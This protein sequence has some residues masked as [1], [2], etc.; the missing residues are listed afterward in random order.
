MSNF[1]GPSYQLNTRKADVQ[2]VVNMLPVMNEVPGGKSA[3]YMKSVPGLEVFSAYSG[4]LVVARGMI[5][6]TAG[7]VMAIVIGDK[8]Y[9]VGYDGVRALLGTLATSTGH[10]GM[11]VGL[12]QLVVVDGPNGY[13]V[14]LDT[15][16]FTQITDPA[17]LGSNTVDYLGGYFTF[18]DPD[19]QTFYISALEDALTFDALE[20]ATANSSPDKLVGQSVTS[21][22]LVL[23]GQV[24]TEV[25]QE[26]G[27]TDFPFEKNT[28]VYI[29]VGLMAAFTAKDLDNSTFWLGKDERGAGIVYKLEGFRA[30]RVSTMAIEQTIQ[31]AISEGNDVSTAV[32]YTY[33]Q[34]GHSFYVLQIP[35]LDTTWTYDVSSKQW[36]ERAELVNGD[37]EQHRGRFHC[38]CF[39]KHLI[40]GDDDIIYEYDVDANTN[41]GDVLVRD[42]ISPHSSVPDLRR[43]S[44]GTFELDCTVGYGIAGQAQASVM[45]RYSDDGGFEWNGWRTATLGAI[46]EKTARARFLRNGS[47]R[48]RVWHTRCT[49]DVPFAIVAASIAAT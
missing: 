29:E 30:V 26:T 7:T 15:G 34:G 10:V 1:V 3:A 47:A 46:G 31:R 22:S 17:W 44:Y 23:F 36:H 20:F 42:R 18:I 32:A 41:A 14:A 43:V 49:D 5:A 6:N 16:V 38:Y 45:M 39:D 12:N 48:D 19:T 33:Q 40:I 2:R 25:W 37:Y 24:A 27:A 21:K 28:G 9:A 13:V 8:L 35:G 11:K 4:G